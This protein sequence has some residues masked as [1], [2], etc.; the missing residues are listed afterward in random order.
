MKVRDYSKTNLIAINTLLENRLVKL[1]YQSK[2][3]SRDIVGGVSPRRDRCRINET[4][5]EMRETIAD[6][7]TINSL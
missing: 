5:K 2:C 3:V 7:I 4:L 1:E 6:L